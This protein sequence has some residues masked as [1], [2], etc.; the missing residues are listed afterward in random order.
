MDFD[1]VTSIARFKTETNYFRKH[2]LLHNNKGTG[3]VDVFTEDMKI[4]LL[5]QS[6]CPMVEGQIS[7]LCL[8]LPGGNKKFKDDEMELIEALLA[9][10]DLDFDL[11]Y[12][13]KHKS[14]CYRYCI[15]VLR[16]AKDKTDDKKA[17]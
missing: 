2:Q 3:L 1:F 9:E 13:E 14:E 11:S 5:I 17:A 12:V 6:G 15:K 10:S 8:V 16:A 4:A 7:D